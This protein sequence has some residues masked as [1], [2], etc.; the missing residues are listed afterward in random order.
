LLRDKRLIESELLVV[1]WLRGDREA[2]AGVVRLWERSLFYYVRR[3]L[4]S[5]ADAWEVLHETWLKVL[6]SGK[7]LRDPGAFPAFLYRTARNAAVSRLRGR[8]IHVDERVEEVG[9]EAGENWVSGFDDAEEV[10]RALDKLPV[11]QREVLT[12]FF[13]KELSLEE[14]A[15]VLEI[16]VGTVKSRLHQARRAI[17]R[18][19]E[20]DGHVGR[21]RRISRTIARGTG[22]VGGTGDEASERG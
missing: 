6:K 9:D 1:R 14:I 11:A 12:L 4:E 17:R 21:E 3:L 8:A 7:S 19:I 18:V 20:G 2:F 22:D 16:P 13:L 15:A 5:E 10:H